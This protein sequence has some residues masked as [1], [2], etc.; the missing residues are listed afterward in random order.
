M[1]ILVPL[2]IRVT[3]FTT[4][5]FDKQ[6]KGF[7]QY[8][9]SMP[10]LTQAEDQHLVDGTEVRVNVLSSSNTAEGSV[11]IDKQTGNRLFVWNQVKFRVKSGYSMSQSLLDHLADEEN[12]DTVYIM[13]EEMKVPLTE[14]MTGERVGP[15][16]IDVF[17][18]SVPNEAQYVYKL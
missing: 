15:E 10:S 2:Y 16:N 4:A 5:Y 6:V 9:N 1:R 14:I 18:G 17:N 8:M 13:E 3:V 7:R 11:G 12:I